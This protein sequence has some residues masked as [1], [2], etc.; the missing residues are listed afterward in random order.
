MKVNYI[1]KQDINECLKISN[2]M[3]PLLGPKSKDKIIIEKDGTVS[4]TNDGSTFL[5]LMVIS[6]K[7]NIRK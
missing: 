2:S 1:L 5:N 4:V 3:K 6:Y 7:T